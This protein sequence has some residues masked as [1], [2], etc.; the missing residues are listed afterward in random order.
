MQAIFLHGQQSV[1]KTAKK[2]GVTRFLLVGLCAAAV[3]MPSHAMDKSGKNEPERTAAGANAPVG[4]AIA[5]PAPEVRPGLAGSFLSGRFAK[6]NQDLQISARYLASTLAH[7]PEN[8]GLQQETMR[9]HLLAGNIESATVLAK[10]LAQNKNNDPLIASLLMLEAVKADDFARAK[11]TIEQAPPLGL[12]GLIRPVMLEWIALAEEEKKHVV[13]LQAAIDKAGFFAPFI[14][15]HAGLMHDVMG[16]NTA[17]KTAYVKASSDAS[18]TPY[19]VVEAIANFHE[20]QNQMQEAQAV[21][22][23]YAKANPQST[24]IPAKLVAGSL[25]KPLVGDAKQGL[26]ELF[27]TTA[28][29]LFGESATQ[30]T[31]LYLR[32]ALELRPN[33]PP[34]QLMLA[35][36]YEQMENYKQAIATYDAIPEGSVFYRRA[37]VRKA[38]NYEALGQK[39]KALE[40][41]EM[42]A[43]RYPEDATPLITKGDIERD[44]KNYFAAAETYSAA[45]SRTEPLQAND[46]PLL[47]ARGISYERDGEWSKAESD[48]KRALTLAPEQPD[49][50]NYLAYS[51]LTMNKNLTKAREY[52]EIASAQRPD[53]AHIIDS[54]GWAYYLAGDFKTAVEHFERAISALPDD[55][56][57]NEHLGDAYWRVERT[58]EA[59]FQWQRALANKPEKDVAEA[60]K[61]K[62]DKGLPAFAGVTDKPTPATVATT[63]ARI[64]VQ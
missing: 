20:R 62:L 1:P 51:W 46:W 22:D 48:F 3:V 44:A 50:L 55:A 7:D 16:N 18:V 4:E 25:P 5:K 30:D 64:Q 23:A 47:Y 36:L 35:N 56:T 24:L 54:V 45:I 39:P 49:V 63:P 15:Y 29:I 52:L 28:S 53:D 12:F 43:N 26:A 33:L 32:I 11:T 42:L 37:Q 31:F 38:L 21:Y 57:V 17:A 61:V 27:F 34:A 40:L 41:L 10:K 59:R 2:L 9:M 14:Y 8:E 6:Q 58:T 13:N 19:R 60:L